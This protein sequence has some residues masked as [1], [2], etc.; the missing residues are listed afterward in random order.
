MKLLNKKKSAF[1]LIE[2]LIVI[3]IIGVLATIAFVSFSGVTNK[4]KK[5]TA[6][7]TV[8]DVKTKLG[9]YSTEGDTFPADKA[10]VVTWLSSSTGGNSPDLSAKFNDSNFTYTASPASCTTDCTGFTI[11]ANGALWGKSGENITQTN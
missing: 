8:A 3:I 2:L 10:A 9:Q 11:V 4:S 5:A 1:T 7:S 6:Q